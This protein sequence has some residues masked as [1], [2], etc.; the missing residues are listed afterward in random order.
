MKVTKRLGWFVYYSL[1]YVGELIGVMGFLFF[2]ASLCLI[3]PPFPSDQSTRF[4][5]LG[6]MLF[7]MMTG[8]L[9]AW[10]GFRISDHDGPRFWLR[11]RLVYGNDMNIRAV[12]K[13]SRALR[14][15][16]IYWG[17]Q[18]TAQVLTYFITGDRTD[19]LNNGEQ[20]AWDA[21]QQYL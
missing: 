9:I 21:Y 7:C 13:A 18:Y 12:F 2:V 5:L 4:A 19:P 6:I 14:R 1:E 17:A 20:I 15:S 11:L 16:G 3:G 8:L 10:A